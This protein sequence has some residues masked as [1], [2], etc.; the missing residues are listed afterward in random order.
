MRFILAAFV[1]A[2]A[3]AAIA[4]TNPVYRLAYVQPLKG[5]SP[6][7]DYLTLDPGRGLLFLGRRAAGVTIYDVRKHAVVGEVENA[8]GANDATLV[9]EFGRGYTT[10]GDG[11]TTVFDLATV[12][13]I[14]RIKIGE[15]A[16]AAFYDPATKQLAFTLGD[17]H[18]LLFI[19]AKTAAIGAQLQL[20]GHEIEGVAPD[21][22]GALFVVERDIA[23]VAKVDSRSHVLVSEWSLPGCELPTGVAL[24]AA[25]GR[26]FLG[27]KGDHPVLTVIDTTGGRIVAQLPTGRGNDGV[28]YDP[29]SRRVYTANGVDGNIVIFDQKGP[30]AYVLSQAVTTRP[31]ARTLA[32]DPATRKLYTMTAEGMVDPAKKVNLRAGAFYPNTYFDDTFT[33]LEYGP[34]TMGSKGEADDE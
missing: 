2:F 30:D 4:A 17:A 14:K 22:K 33:L 23:K 24:D 16:D 34:V 21:G 1:A 9:P 32:F 12:K 8:A 19:D 10:N 13:A 6:S 11:S 20:P 15:D 7:W 5:P 28:V 25:D 26:L 29:G 27:C 18:S 31:I 3:G